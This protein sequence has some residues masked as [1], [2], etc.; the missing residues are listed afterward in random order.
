M[1]KE[2]ISNYIHH[3]LQKVL[4]SATRLENDFFNL[5]TVNLLLQLLNVRLLRRESVRVPAASAAMGQLDNQL[6]CQQRHVCGRLDNWQTHSRR[7]HRFHVV[8]PVVDQLFGVRPV[9]CVLGHGL[10]RAQDLWVED[11]QALIEEK[12]QRER[13]EM[14]NS[15]VSINSLSSHSRHGHYGRQP[16]PPSQLSAT[17]ARETHFCIVILSTEKRHCGNTWD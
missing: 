1:G 5:T 13:L 11:C 2:I 10:Q 17:R 12:P 4:I 8:Q 9:G 14:R 7:A 16:G 15:A 6:D 3:H